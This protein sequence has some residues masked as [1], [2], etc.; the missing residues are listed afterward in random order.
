MATAPDDLDVW[1][2]YRQFD[3]KPFM[4]WACTIEHDPEAP[5][6]FRV[7]ATDQAVADTA[8][9]EALDRHFR[10]PVEDRSASRTSRGIADATETLN[11]G[12][13][14]YFHAAVR[15]IPFAPFGP[16]PAR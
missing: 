7:T 2:L 16:A 14:G 10:E 4:R 13:E 8:F 15:A 11:P 5:A 1:H 3:T 12:D 6:K 9:L